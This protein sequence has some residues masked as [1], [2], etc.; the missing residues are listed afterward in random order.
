MGGMP[1][2][3]L[4]GR[5]L[6]GGIFLENF[7]ENQLNSVCI[8]GELYLQGVDLHGLGYVEGDGFA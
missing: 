2:L 1:P 3:D 7:S 8:F 6:L 4:A 5:L